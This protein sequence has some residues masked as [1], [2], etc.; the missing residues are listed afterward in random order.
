MGL[1]HSPSTITNSLVLLLDAA[2]TKSYPGSG[3]SWFDISGNSN[4]GTLTNGPTYSSTNSG[5]I[6]F[7]SV[8]DYILV[9]SSASIPYGATA[10][11]I[12]IW[13][14][15]NSTT[16][17]N[18]VNNLFFYG[19]GATGQ[20]FGIDFS[21]YPNMEIFTWGGTGRD[22]TFASTYAQVGW[23]NICVTYDGATTIYVYEN[24]VLTRTLTL[25]SACNTAS[26]NVFIG[27]INPAQFAGTFDGNISN[28]SI[29]S[30]A[31]S[32]DEIAQNFNA[33]RGRY[34]I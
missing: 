17:Q 23:K 1:V 28:T 26:S 18:D 10:R 25:T 27:A 34:G 24:A 20:A 7:D 29:Y 31:L 32:A 3:T 5:S 6:V 9:N 14:Y 15:T 2:N 21:T 30:R 22:L 4:T 11:S 13:F 16:W 12:N 33:L 19:S 8:N